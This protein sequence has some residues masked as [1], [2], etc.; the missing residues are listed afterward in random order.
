RASLPYTVALVGEQAARTAF[1]EL[2]AGDALFERD[3]RPPDGMV[4]TVRRGPVT[5][6]RARMRD[7]SVEELRWPRD[8]APP[9]AASA[10]ATSAIAPRHAEPG[11]LPGGPLW[12]RLLRWLRALGDA[13]A[14]S[15]PAPRPA[16]APA[17]ASDPFV[18]AVRTLSDAGGR[19]DEVDRLF[20]ELAGGLLDKDVAIV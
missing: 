9:P 19:G 10:P 16:L 4:L 17:R 5:E 12:R 8:G 11:Q 20:L 2:L 3:R 15:A 18:A 6:C 13:R 14:S 7:G 1:L